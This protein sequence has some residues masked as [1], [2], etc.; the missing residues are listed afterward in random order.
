MRTKIE[1][2]GLRKAFAS[3]RGT[4]PVI[5]DVTLNVRDG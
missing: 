2:K 1:V 4:L 5:E 3:D